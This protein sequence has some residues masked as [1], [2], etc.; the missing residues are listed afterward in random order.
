VNPL[1]KIVSN[2]AKS[3]GNQC[4]FAWLPFKKPLLQEVN[5]ILCNKKLRR[6]TS[7]SRV[8][9]ISEINS[10]RSSETIRATTIRNYTTIRCYATLIRYTSLRNHTNLRD[11]TS[12]R[13]LTSLRDNT[14]L[15][16]HTSLREFSPN[17]KE[18]VLPGGESPDNDFL[19]WLAGL[20]DGDGSFFVSKKG[21]VSC[22]ISLHSKE[23]QALYMISKYFG[24]SVK[25]RTGVECYCWRL[26]KTALV[27]E[28][29]L[30]MNGRLQDYN[31]RL[32]LKRV[33]LVSMSSNNTQNFKEDSLPRFTRVSKKHGGL[34]P[35]Q[36]GIPLKNYNLDTVP[37]KI[38]SNTSWISGFFDAEGSIN[39][40]QSTLQLSL[41]MSQKK[42]D[43]LIQIQEALKVG[44]IYFDKLWKGYIYYIISQKDLAEVF[45]YFDKFPNRIPPKKANYITLKRLWLYKERNYHFKSHPKHKYF[46]R[47]ARLL[48]NRK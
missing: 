38:S 21:D 40:K 6:E 14:S 29:A 18:T 16:N 3:A 1:V 20:I 43:L 35:T 48:A 11:H 23:V 10:L 19:D 24:G 8:F 31:K 33:I 12:L 7:F 30:Y 32:Q 25:K 47:L 2:G 27:K 45:K 15:R 42:P 13:N 44:N 41:S 17:Q 4:N 9:S 37:K 46:L 26:H 28:L 36:N 34:R 5:A 22:E 39:C